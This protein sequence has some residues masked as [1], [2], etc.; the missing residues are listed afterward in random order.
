MRRQIGLLSVAGFFGLI[1]AAN[2][3]TAPPG[4]TGTAFDGTYKFVSS[5]KVNEMYTS[6]NGH[7]GMCPDRKP[8]TLHIVGG[9]V[10]YTAATGYRFG[11]T[12]G[13]QGELTMR[14]E[15]VGGSRPA[16]MQASGAIDGS[17]VVHVRQMGSSCS[18]DFVW[19]RR[20]A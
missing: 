19:Q 2:A 15:M 18:Y 6:Y 14:S 8:G 5:T 1:A 16:R 4:T 20:S 10:H 11:G 3:Q 12:V 7:S 13:S 17:G 9:R